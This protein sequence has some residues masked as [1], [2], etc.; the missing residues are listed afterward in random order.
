MLVA[1]LLYGNI[2]FYSEKNTCSQQRKTLY[3]YV[4]MCILI[5]PSSLPIFMYSLNMLTTFLPFDADDYLNFNKRFGPLL[6]VGGWLSRIDY[7]NFQSEHCCAF[8]N[9]PFE[10]K[11][12]ISRLNCQHYYHIECVQ[13]LSSQGVCTCP[14]CDAFIN[15]KYQN[16]G[17][18]F[19]I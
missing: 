19:E 9:L 1:W 6:Q 17:K 16:E 18:S 7:L 13:N 15:F 10:N 2:L 12:L 5:V 4:L 14:Q 11:H 8:C 3:L